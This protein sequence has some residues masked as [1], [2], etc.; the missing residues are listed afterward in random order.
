MKPINQSRFLIF[1]AVVH[2]PS[3]HQSTIILG[4][5]KKMLFI[6]NLKC[7]YG[8][9]KKDKITNITDYLLKVILHQTER[10]AF[11]YKVNKKSKKILKL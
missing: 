3:L 9:L 10:V 2:P 6:N 4:N 1:N 11:L 5:L 7:F 8:I